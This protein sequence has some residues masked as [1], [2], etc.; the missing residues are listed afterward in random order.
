MFYEVFDRFAL[1]YCFVFFLL[2]FLS[3]FCVC[4]CFVEKERG[5]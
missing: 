4:F 5:E 3:F 1:S 2:S